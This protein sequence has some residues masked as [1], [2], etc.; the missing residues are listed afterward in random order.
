MT[1]PGRKRAVYEDLFTIPENTTGEIIDGELFVTPR[2][3][4]R[5]AYSASTLDKK[6]GPPYQFGE[7]GPGGWI[8]LVEPEIGFGENILVPD[9]GGWK[10]ERFPA[11]EEHNWISAPPDWVC[12][13]LSPST[14]RKDKT[15]KMPLYAAHGVSHLWLLEPVAKSLDVFRL[16][17]GRW[18]LLASFA[19]DDPVRAEPFREIE[20]ELGSLW[21]E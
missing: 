7:G 13:I 14:A 19:E 20:F 16:E 8:I 3:S 11:H 15:G 18:S 9:L 6:V 17:S 12:E 10:R 5:H 1:E 2:P 21:L 4:R